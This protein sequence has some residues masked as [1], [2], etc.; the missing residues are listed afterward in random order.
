MNEKF[1]FLFFF[2]RLSAGFEAFER[3]HSSSSSGGSELGNQGAFKS[4]DQLSGRVFVGFVS[5]CFF[6]N[7]VKTLSIA[8]LLRVHI[9][10][11]VGGSDHPVILGCIN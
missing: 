10:V 7:T 5:G 6:T 3:N 9:G 11:G 4:S 1:F 2:L 8:S